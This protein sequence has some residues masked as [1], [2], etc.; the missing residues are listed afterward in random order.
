M[1]H[2]FTLLTRT[3]QRAPKKVAHLSPKRL[4]SF[5]CLARFTIK[6]LKEH[7]NIQE[8]GVAL[9]TS[10]KMFSPLVI[11]LT[12]FECSRDKKSDQNSQ[13]SMKL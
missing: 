4:N 5:V 9:L 6:S 10:S 1:V 11:F 2:T 13:Y 7:L 3:D 12:F 8:E